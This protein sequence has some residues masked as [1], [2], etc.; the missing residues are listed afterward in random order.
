MSFGL[1]DEKLFAFY[2]LEIFAYNFSS[3]DPNDVKTLRLD[4]PGY[5]ESNEP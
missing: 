4:A 3:S 1:I 5:D 2:Y